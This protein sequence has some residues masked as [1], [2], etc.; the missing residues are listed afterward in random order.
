MA[1]G[2]AANDGGGAVIPTEVR[3]LGEHASDGNLPPERTLYGRV[4]GHYRCSGNTRDSIAV[5]GLPTVSKTR[6]KPGEASRKAKQPTHQEVERLFRELKRTGDPRLRER[7]IQMHLNLVRFLARKFANRGEPTDDLVQVGNIGLINAVDRFDP[8]RGIRFATYATPTI[9]GEIKRYFR[10]RGWA[11]KV[12]RRLQE[13]NLAANKAIDS[14]VQR[15]DRSPTVAEIA[16]SVGTTEEETIEAIELGHM[17]E[18]VSLDSEAGQPDDESHTVLADYVGEDDSLF[19][20]IG[21][22]SSLVDAL[23]RLPERERQIIELRFF[24][25]MSQTDVAQRLGISQMHVSRLQ[26]KALA[27][28]REFVRGEQ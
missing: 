21:A 23:K 4:C 18:L 28:L 6:Q 13:I 20:E 9:V 14:L 5:H 22:R 19:D 24:R 2:P 8:E 10:D 25:N 3:A 1:R 16:Q 12:P 15:F 7:L 11:I 26:Q 17:Y 27:R